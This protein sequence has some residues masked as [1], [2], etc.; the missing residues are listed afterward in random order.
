M[1]SPDDLLTTQKNGVI[2]INALNETWLRSQGKATS[3]TISADTLITAVRG[4]LVNVSVVVAG[5]TPGEIYNAATSAG[6]IA[7]NLLAIAPNTAGVYPL[8]IVFS[9]GIYIK[10]GTGQELNITYSPTTG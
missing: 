9:S 8:G 6:A 3:L 10:I 1:A 4:Y 7:S 2:A 5:T